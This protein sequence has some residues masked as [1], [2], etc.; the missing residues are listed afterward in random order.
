VYKET[1]T[2]VT[3]YSDDQTDSPAALRVVRSVV[4]LSASLF[5]QGIVA[6]VGK[7]V[8]GKVAPMRG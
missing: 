3:D 6:Q 8:A 5:V 7:S 2:T 4:T 1:S